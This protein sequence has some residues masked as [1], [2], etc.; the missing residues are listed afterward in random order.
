MQDTAPGGKSFDVLSES[1]PVWLRKHVLHRLIQEEQNGARDDAR[2]ETHITPE[3]YNFRLLGTDTL[4]GRAV[5]LLEA[6]PK[7]KNKYLFRGRVWVDVDD[8]AVARIE[9]SPAQNPSFWT[10]KIHFTHRYQKV[11]PFWLALSNGSETE[12]R[13]FGSTE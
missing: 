12:V 6:M 7:T 11:G 1:G 13:I 5:Y 10:T 3:N 2:R 8:A 9:G 4:D